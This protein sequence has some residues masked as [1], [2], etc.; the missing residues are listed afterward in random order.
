M[1]SVQ[2]W[3][4]HLCI[5]SAYSLP[6]VFWRKVARRMVAGAAAANIRRRGEIAASRRQSSEA[7]K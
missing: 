3:R 1:V 5:I 2:K 6:S 7:G 4:Y